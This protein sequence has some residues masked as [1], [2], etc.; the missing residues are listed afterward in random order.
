MKLVMAGA[1]VATIATMYGC[2]GLSK[3]ELSSA[4]RAQTTTIKILAN[5]R[6]PEDM[7]FH[8]KAQSAA[9]AFGVVGALAGMAMAGSP[10]A[11]ILETMNKHN[12]LLPM[13]LR[14]EFSKALQSQQDF[15]VVDETS[16]ADADMLLTVNVYGLGQSHGFS[17][18][19][20]ILNVSAS[21]RKPDGRVIWQNTDYVTALNKENNQGHEFDEYIENPELLRGTWSV[22][23]SIVSRMLVRELSQRQ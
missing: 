16:P 8:G 9:G 15:R 23:C 6:M 19:Y 3:I 5:E 14:T 4:D 17:K 2:T 1:L 18:L 7:F 21:L 22:A 10:K 12:I 13:I 20:P 11:Q